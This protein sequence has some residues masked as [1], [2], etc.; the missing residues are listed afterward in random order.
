MMQLFPQKWLR[1]A[2]RQGEGGKL[3]GRRNNVS[4]SVA[5]TALLL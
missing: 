1:S 2:F 3:T 4:L 5:L